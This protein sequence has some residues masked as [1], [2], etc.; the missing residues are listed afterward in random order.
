VIVDPLTVATLVSLLEYVIAPVLT[1]V[2][3]VIVGAA[4][5]ML[6][7]VALSANPVSVGVPVP[8][9]SDAVVAALNATENVPCEAFTVVIV[10]VAA[11][12]LSMVRI[13]PANV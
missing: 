12:T 8:T 2:G 11:S 13:W 6:M 3:A 9:V 7:L 4:S 1:D 10:N 5:P